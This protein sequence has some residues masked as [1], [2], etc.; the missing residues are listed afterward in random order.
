MYPE[1]PK[2]SIDFAVMEKAPHVLMVEL[3]CKTWRDVGSWAVLTDPELLKLDADGN[4]IVA[5]RTSIL[6]SSRNVIFSEDEHL[7]AVLGM[8]GCIIVHTPDATLVC[9][10]SDS[11]RVRDLVDQINR[12]FGGDY[13]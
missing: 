1:L 8:E 3:T 12:Q 13:A 6:D 5:A 4:A 11:Q 7:V 10:E 2:I 9:N